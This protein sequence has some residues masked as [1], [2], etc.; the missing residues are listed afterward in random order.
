VETSRGLKKVGLCGRDVSCMLLICNA[1]VA[2]N[3]PRPGGIYRKYTP[4]LCI[5]PIAILTNEETDDNF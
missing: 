1:A 4:E 3:G 5:R 2:S